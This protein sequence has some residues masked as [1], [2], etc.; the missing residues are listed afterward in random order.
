[1]LLKI[2]GVKDDFA[3]LRR[4]KGEGSALRR[5]ARDGEWFAIAAVAGAI[6]PKIRPRNAREFGG[7]AS[8]NVQSEFSEH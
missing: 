2:K 7:A 3:S 4:R 1:M 8:T 5:M 6:A